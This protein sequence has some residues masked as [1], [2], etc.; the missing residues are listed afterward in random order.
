MKRLSLR[1][2]LPVLALCVA[3]PAIGAQNPA[4]IDTSS[5]SGSY[6]AGRHASK[7]RDL[8]LAAE[9]FAQALRDDPNNSVL[10]ERTFVLAFSAGDLDKAEDLA[11]PVLSLDP[12]HRLARIILG[13]KEFRANH[14]AAALDHFK[15]IDSTPLDELTSQL[16]I[17]WTAAAQKNPKAAFAALDKLGRNDYFVIFRDFHGALIS[18][19]LGQ[20][21][22]AEAFYKKAY[23]Q[24]GTSN[25]V[26]QAYGN[27]LERNGKAAEARKIYE[28]FLGNDSDQPIIRKVLAELNKGKVP[29]RFVPDAANGIA[30][31]MFSI[32]GWLNDEQT[33]DAALIYAQLALLMRKDFTVAQILLGNIFES[34]G[35]YDKAIEAYDLVSKTDVLQSKAAIEIAVNLHQLERAEEALEKISA[36]LAADPANY[37]A[38]LTKADFLRD[39]KRFT[40]AAEAYTRALS[41]VATPDRNHALVYYFRGIAYERSQQWD[42]A[43]V[44]FRK[45]L[46]LLPDQANVL[47]YLG[48]SMVDKRVNLTE[49]LQMIRK[50]VEL[51]PNDGYIVDSLGWAHYQ[52]REYEEAVK[53]L[54]RAVE[55]RPEDPI[56]NEH[57][58]DAYW[59]AGRRLE[60]RFQWQHAKDNKPEK[61]DLEKIQR[62]LE[63]GMPEEPPVPATTQSDA[64]KTVN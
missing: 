41:L 3:L 32:A 45:S 37:D 42:K 19:L 51:K 1:Y 18:D 15:Q 36:V 55:L 40:E 23:E 33:I 28:Q 35:R 38:W 13:L 60:A 58:G 11:V 20:P 52:L 31:T 6:L 9:Y 46:A 43:E 7:I 56:I 61:P 10:I 49:A 64:T 2:C 27:F 5:L 48:Y 30:E 25:R 34:T 29:K 22:R 4:A 39:A 21:T 47:N 54:E 16:L 17:A 50:A 12:K 59:R 63:Q 44:D 53:H 26:I 14:F 8:D 62:K 57:L 24:A